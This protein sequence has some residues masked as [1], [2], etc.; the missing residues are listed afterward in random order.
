MHEARRSPEVAMLRRRALLVVLLVVPP[1]LA[2]R[3]VRVA[4][5]TRTAP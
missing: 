3:C 4:V 2:F 5:E 1:L